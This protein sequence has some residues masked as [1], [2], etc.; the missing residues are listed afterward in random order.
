MM[1][2]DEPNSAKLRRLV[3][4]S[5]RLKS[6][7]RRAPFAE[8]FDTQQVELMVKKERQERAFEIRRERSDMVD[9]RA[10]ACDFFVA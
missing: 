7:I 2:E 10:P 4:K 1:D 8:P 3:D 9:R 6:A 5:H